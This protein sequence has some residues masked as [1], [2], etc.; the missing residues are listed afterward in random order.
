MEE[1][2]KT[3]RRGMLKLSL[4]TL[5]A[6]ALS[7]LIPHSRVGRP[8]ESRKIGPLFEYAEFRRLN[9]VYDAITKI[10]GREFP[11]VYMHPY[12]LYALAVSDEF[13]TQFERYPLDD[14][15]R[16]RLFRVLGRDLWASSQIDEHT[17]FFGDGLFDAHGA[18][19]YRHS[20]E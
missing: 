11:N 13:G 7:G 9:D 17:V 2:V 12:M 5:G 1:N 4:A 3:S 8:S 19:P 18:G 10:G 6:G 16:G 15:M 20:F 14:V